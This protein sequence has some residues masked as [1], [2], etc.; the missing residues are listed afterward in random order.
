MIIKKKYKFHAAHRNEE[1]QDKCRNLH[2]H[3][4]VLRCFFRVKRNGSI[5]TL[6]GD[7]DG[8]IEPFL[9]R[10]Y[11]HAML[12]N[13]HDGLYE[14]LCDYRDRSGD[15]LKLKRFESPTSVENLAHQLFSE[16]SAMGFNLDRLEVQETDTS[17]VIYTR[18]DWLVYNQRLIEHCPASAREITV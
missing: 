3:R 10:E 1:I 15:S 12:I 18:R 13:V 9:K 5:S 7:F 6:F 4:Y 17:T 11:D 14:A 2:G 8:K 16:I